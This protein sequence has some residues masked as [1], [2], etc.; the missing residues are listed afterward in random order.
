[1]MTP[2]NSSASALLSVPPMPACSLFLPRP[3]AATR[4]AARV[5][6]LLMALSAAA[7]SQT[8]VVDYAVGNF[9]SAVSLSVNAAGEVL[10][11]DA[12]VNAC[13]RL[14]HDGTELARVQGTGWGSAE[15]D[16]PTDISGMFP[17]AVFVADGK[18]KRV[19]QF[20]KDLHYVQTIDELQTTDGQMLDG[21]FRP[22]ASA[23]SSQGELFV[24]DADGTR[25]IKYTTRLRVEREFGTYASGDGRLKAPADICIT[26]DGRVAVADGNTVVYF[27][28]FGN[29]LSMQHVAGTEPIRALSASG[30]DIIA[31]TTDEISILNAA[32]G[33]GPVKGSIRAGMIVGDSAVTFRDAARVED[34]W[35]VLTPK[36][37]LVCTRT[38]K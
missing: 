29:Y 35:Y 21:G 2:L 32:S 26:D 6:L 28:Q 25:I 1:M 7:V 3:L 20:D 30:G 16:A 12:G 27:D 37:L 11:L 8:L 36:Q 34:R 24:L 22:I 15:L 10:V 4:C 18:N 5:M 33:S 31:V 38:D 17:L 19:Q 13:I 23:Q 9:T 14:R